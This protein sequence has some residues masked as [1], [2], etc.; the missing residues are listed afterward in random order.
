MA[1]VITEST[2]IEHIVQSK[3]NYEGEG[4]GQN[5]VNGRILEQG[6]DKSK[7]YDINQ[8]AQNKLYFRKN[9]DPE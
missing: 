3:N 7:T 4:S 9:E 1:M 8:T 2:K 5:E 6:Q